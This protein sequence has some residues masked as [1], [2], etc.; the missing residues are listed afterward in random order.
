MD[1]ENQKLTEYDELPDAEATE[2]GVILTP[3][4]EVV[5]EKDI[6]KLAIW[7]LLASGLIFIGAATARIFVAGDGVKDVWDYT[8]SFIAPIVTLVL[9]LYFGNKTN[10]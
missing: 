4:T 2:K 10:R 8:K 6:F 9:G 3:K 1:Q 7:V 5:S